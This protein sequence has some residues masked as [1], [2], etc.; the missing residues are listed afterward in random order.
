MSRT[1]RI[2][3]MREPIVPQATIL[4]VDDSPTNLQVLVRTLEG[5]G[6]RILAAKNGKAALEIVQRTKPDLV[7]LDVMMP[8]MDG[9]AV[10]RALKAD[11]RTR[12]IVVIFLSALGEVTDKVQG[13][14]LGAVDYI[15][16]PIQTEEVMARVS[17]HLSRQYLWRELRRSRD[18]LDK[19]LA[20]AAEMQRMILPRDFPRGLGLRFAAH[21]QTSRYAGG[22]YYDVLPLDGGRCGVFV[23]D[24]SG[25][26]APAAIVMAMIRALVHALPEGAGADPAAVFHHVNRHFRFLWDTNIFATAC[27]AVIDGDGV[28]IASA[29]HPLP[30]FL[31]CGDAREL[32]GSATVPLLFQELGDVPVTRHELA[33]GDRLLF[34]TDGITERQRPDDAM[35]DT[36][37][38]V[39]VLFRN[40]REEPAE[41]LRRVVADVEAFA[42]GRESE[43]DQTLLLVARD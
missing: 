17:N 5:G 4:V 23:A 1:E 10:C 40:C 30:M 20:S 14:E 24:V 43:D 2:L 12:D 21:Y 39:D 28:T 36:E 42:G 32:E 38:L 26:G 3:L 22:D 35:Y 8:E 29:G 41:L 15:T 6:H 9:F 7:L 34:Y 25:H 11:P 13:L 16:K 27:Y 31:R 19:E 33:S 18:R 37:R